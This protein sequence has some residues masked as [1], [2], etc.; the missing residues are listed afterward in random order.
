MPSL[1]DSVFNCWSG[2]RSEKLAE[3]LCAFLIRILPEL[4]G[5]VHISTQLRKG[6]LWFDAIMSQLERA[7][8]GVLCL[9]AEN[10]RSPWVHFEAGALAKGLNASPPGN[11]PD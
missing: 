1:D 8:A 6:V 10:L 11:S 4:D 2:T 7:R 5:R 3:M 9:N